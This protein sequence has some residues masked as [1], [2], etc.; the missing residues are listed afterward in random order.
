MLQ[1]YADISALSFLE[2]FK[3]DNV[4][5]STFFHLLSLCYFMYILIYQ[6]YLSWCSLKFILLIYQHFS[7]DFFDV[8]SGFLLIHQYSLFWCNLKLILLIHQHFAAEFLDVAT[9]FY[10]YINTLLL[11]KAWGGVCWYINIFHWIS[12]C[13]LRFL[14]IFQHSLIW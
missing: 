10:W 4:D 11:C 1:A 2:I 13:C 9:G 8:A 5:T 14:L 7:T 12:W 3:V 6:H